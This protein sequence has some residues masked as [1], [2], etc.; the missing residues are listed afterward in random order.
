MMAANPY[1]LRKPLTDSRLRHTFLSIE[2]G[3]RKPIS[4]VHVAGLNRLFS[5]FFELDV[6]LNLI[7]LE[8]AY[9]GQLYLLC[10]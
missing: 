8:S 6:V 2:C 1:P 7:P 4:A 5:L 9:M 3:Q 10:S